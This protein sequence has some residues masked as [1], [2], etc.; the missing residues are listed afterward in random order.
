MADALRQKLRT[1]LRLGEAWAIVKGCHET[2]SP[3][4]KL[5]EEVAWLALSS[6]GDVRAEIDRVLAPALA[7]LEQGRWDDIAPWAA[8]APPT[9]EGG[10][11]LP[12]GLAPGARRN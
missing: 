10:P 1:D 4:I 8:D 2:I 5:E 11:H 3:A 7:A 9:A 12:R 6:P